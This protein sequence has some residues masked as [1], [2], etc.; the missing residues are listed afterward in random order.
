MLPERRAHLLAMV[1][2]AG[3]AHKDWVETGDSSLLPE[4]ELY[5]RFQEL[6]DQSRVIFAPRAEDLEKLI[7]AFSPHWAAYV[8]SQQTTADITMLPSPELWAAWE[9][10]QHFALA[11][12]MPRLKRI[13]SIAQLKEEKV[14]TRQICMIYGFVEPDGVT[15][16]FAKLDE[17][18]REP[19]KHTGAGT[20]WVA[21]VNRDLAAKIAQMTIDAEQISA[22]RS[23]KIAAA[24]TPARESIES[25]LA[26]TP[27]VSAVQIARM[28]RITVEQVFDYCR[29]H[30]LPAPALD[31]T[32]ELLAPGA[33]DP[34][35]S[36]ERQAALGRLGVDT[37]PQSA[38]AGQTLPPAVELGPPLTPGQRPGPVGPVGTASDDEE[39]EPSPDLPSGIDLD[40]VP[41]DEA[42]Q[43]QEAASYFT[44]GMDVAQ[45]SAAMG[46]NGNQVRGLLK[47]AGYSL[48]P[49][50]A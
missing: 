38:G 34:V 3:K 39:L 22:K 33:H 47:K 31:Y 6:A 37:S 30:G 4:D 41:P 40:T 21:P 10:L 36:T 8:T 32:K 19:G 20:G 2:G 29:Q 18:I 43:I 42:N 7:L 13:E 9:A 50:G 28:K 15:P 17:E 48:T 23:A 26:L 11:A 44:Q 5:Q 16:D 46:V 25:L 1:T 14:S 45:I 27:P 35:V 49:A 12:T 24:V